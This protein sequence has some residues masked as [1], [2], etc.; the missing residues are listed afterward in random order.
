[1]SFRSLCGD[2]GGRLTRRRLSIA[3][4]PRNKTRF[5]L[6]AKCDVL[7]PVYNG[8]STVD[9][10]VASLLAQTMSDLRVI[11]VDDGSAQPCA[12]LLQ[13]IAASDPR[14]RLIR[15]A[16][17]GIV[18]ALNR[19]LAETDAPVIARLD[20]DDRAAPDRLARQLACFEA[21]PDIVATSGAVRHIDSAGEVIGL[22]RPGDPAKADPDH[23]PA[24]EPFLIH[25]FLAVRR[26]A[27]EAIGGYRHVHHAEDA[28][29]FWRLSERGR[30]Y[31]LPEVLGDYRIHD[32]SIS[33]GSAV[34]GRIQAI[35]SQLAAISAKRRRAKLPDLLFTPS[36]LADYQDATATAA[37]MAITE[38]TLGPEER[39]WL[40]VA[41]A[42]KL[43]ELTSYRPWKLGNDDLRFIRSV[44]AGSRGTVSAPA[45]RELRAMIQRGAAAMLLQGRL[46]EAT[47]LTEPGLYAG[48][49]ARAAKRRMGPPETAKP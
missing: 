27:L 33:G 23:A 18:A 13:R 31:N 48:A 30:L 45:R 2:G 25:P 15:Q 14:I 40:R 28:D 6:S 47:L 3:L 10:A 34:N 37:M 11:I 24:I 16:N 9:E 22:Y 8:A 12:D 41:V 7:L 35:H 1:L 43:L 46:R 17:A 26:H 32:D 49:L 42:A 5:V 36:Q 39:A 4:L 44:W 29:L 21:N 19:A 20:A 38:A